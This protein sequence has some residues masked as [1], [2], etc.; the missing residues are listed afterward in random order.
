MPLAHSAAADFADAMPQSFRI[1]DYRPERRR[2]GRRKV[3]ATAEARRLDNTLAA[4]REP[5]V[6]ITIL[7]VS[8]GGIA[9]M[10]RSPVVTGERLLVI[11]PP[12]ARLPLQVFG[13]VVR[14]DARRDG[15]FL[16]IRFDSINAA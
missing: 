3:N 8:E 2:H 1:S 16:A 6:R 11:P 4:C 10:S 9:A 5:R 15:W 12:Q 14:C 7:D 13:V